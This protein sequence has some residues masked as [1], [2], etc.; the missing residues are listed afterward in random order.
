MIL[1][2]IPDFAF[3]HIDDTIS[4]VCD[5]GVESKIQLASTTNY[6]LIIRHQTVDLHDSI[7][8][9]A[10]QASFANQA[11]MNSHK[12]IQFR[13]NM[14]HRATLDFDQIIRDRGM[15][16]APPEYPLFE[17]SEMLKQSLK[18]PERE[19]RATSQLILQLLND[20][21]GFNVVEAIATQLHP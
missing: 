8:L 1:T 3:E 5:K 18:H 20:K 12:Q 9:L 21:H 2:T 7:G 4:F 16:T 19:I 13:L 17:V 6:E 10:T 11:T 14:L 15:E